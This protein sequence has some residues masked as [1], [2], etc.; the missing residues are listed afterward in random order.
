MLKKTTIVILGFATS[1][2]V[3]AG[4]MGPVCTPGDVTVPC[5]A[6]LWDLG[7]E[8][9]YLRSIYGADKGYQLKFNPASFGVSSSIND[10]K[11][12]WNWGYRLMGS[13]HYN[14]GND[15][16]VNW[17]HFSST[18]QQNNILAPLPGAFTLFLP[19]YFDS[20]N[21]LDQVNIVIGQHIDLGMSDKMR[22]YGGL[23]YAN[24]QSM[25]Q[26]YIT[27]FIV[28]ELAG[29]PINIFNNTDYKGIGPTIGIDYSYDLMNG[30]SLT[31]NGSGSILY[32]TT[33]YHEGYVLTDFNVIEAQ[34]YARKNTIVPSLEAKLGMNY[35]YN[36]PQAT[37]NINA[38]YQVV[39]YFN[40]L[41]TQTFQITTNPRIASVNY[42]LFGPYF[43]MKFVGNA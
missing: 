15:V 13:F 6:R 12:D 9:L 14:T 3:T 41:S 34:V 36:F 35:A 26:T 5:E 27:D 32:G 20:N 24:I 18:A 42:G 31:A 11:N 38:G 33:R 21:R 2:L 7:A 39:N 43:G 30:L 17:M 37:V 1:G 25:A 29:S 4:S 16:T 19:A 22:L 8:A 23:Q 40:P 28:E 10:V